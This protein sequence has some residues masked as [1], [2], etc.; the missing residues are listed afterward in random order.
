M[1]ICRAGRGLVHF[2]P[3]QTVG[4]SKATVSHSTA[5]PKL[6]PKTRTMLARAKPTF[7]WER[8]IVEVQRRVPTAHV[9]DKKAFSHGSHQLS[10]NTTV[11]RSNHV[12]SFPPWLSEANILP[13]CD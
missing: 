9:G 3:R 13:L 2:L 10:G 12:A 6:L 11:A 5:L 1:G 7:S 8:M 4:P